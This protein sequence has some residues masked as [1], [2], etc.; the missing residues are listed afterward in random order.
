MIKV[1]P[2]ILSTIRLILAFAFIPVFIREQPTDSQ[3]IVA[4]S[5]YVLASVTDVIDGYIARKYSA[6]TN[7]GKILDPLA[8]KLLQ[9]IVSVCIAYVEPMFLIIP[10]FLFIKE[11]LMLAGAIVLYRKKTVLGSNIYGK[12]ASFVYFL[13][14]FVMLGFRQMLNM[15]IKICFIVVFLSVSGL[16]FMRYIQIY[17]KIRKS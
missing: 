2:N 12:V 14:F 9:F 16:A 4:L 11:I 5:I 7:L 15:P 1:I 3:G 6:S 17:I 10:V 13:L 8:D